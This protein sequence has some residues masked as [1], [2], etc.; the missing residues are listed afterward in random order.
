MGTEIERKFL[1][2]LSDWR[3][4]VQS[5]SLIKQGYVAR[6]DGNIVRIRLEEG[7]GLKKA[8]VCIKG[9]PLHGATPE[10]EYDAS[11]SDGET[12]FQLCDNRILTKR[13]HLV[14]HEHHLFEID[15]FLGT[16]SPLVI[17][18]VELATRYQKINLPHWVGT[19][20][21]KDRRYTKAS[22][23]DCGIPK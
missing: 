7:P 8:T 16:L 20:V 5:T 21:S 10:F 19:E 13:R 2:Y 18:E 23:V 15:E 22:L 6:E 1:P 17:I 11:L 9:T 14:Q 12:L 3:Q 4:L